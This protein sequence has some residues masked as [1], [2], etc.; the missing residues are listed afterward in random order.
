MMAPGPLEAL[1]ALLDIVANDERA[2]ELSAALCL[3][4]RSAEQQQSNVAGA[5]AT[6]TAPVALQ[7]PRAHE[8]HSGPAEPYLACLI[9]P[10][11]SWLCVR[12]ATES[13]I[14]CRPDQSGRSLGDEDTFRPRIE[15][16]NPVLG[17]ESSLAALAQS[18][19]LSSF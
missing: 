7:R 3:A 8:R 18:P 13:G 1:P 2:A 10:H 15:R 4:P 16:I 12:R 5:G 17:A 6:V 11:S 9:C 19:P 14:L